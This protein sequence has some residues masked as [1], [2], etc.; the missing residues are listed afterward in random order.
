MATQFPIVIEREASGV[1]SAYVV[2]LPVYAQGATAV[3]AVRAI[4]RTLTAYLEAHPDTRAPNALVKVAMFQ[5]TG[6]KLTVAV[7]G[8]AALI[9]AKTSAR[10]AASARANGQLGGRPRQRPTEDDEAAVRPTHRAR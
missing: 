2:G 10:K 9:G 3:R 8:P 5:L 6:L 1:Y 4:Q 7:R